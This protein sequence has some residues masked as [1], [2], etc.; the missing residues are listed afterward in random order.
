MRAGLYITV[1]AALI[2]P[3]ALEARDLFEGRKQREV[4]YSPLSLEEME[5]CIIEA[6]VSAYPVRLKNGAQT[7]FFLTLQTLSGR[8]LPVWS[9]ERA[10]EGSRFIVYDGRRYFRK[11]RSCFT[12]AQAGE[13]Q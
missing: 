8:N 4:L 6:G 9:L 10:D 5:Q 13:T 2:A 3:S 1:L 7:I 11:A 12:P